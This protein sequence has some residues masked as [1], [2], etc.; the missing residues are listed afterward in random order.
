MKREKMYRLG[1]FLG[2]C[3]AEAFVT[4]GDDDVAEKWTDVVA[5]TF[6]VAGHLFDGKI[7][8]GIVVE[9]GKE[10]VNA[11]NFFS[12]TNLQLLFLDKFDHIFFQ[13]FIRRGR[14][15]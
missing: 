4:V 6:Q 5:E 14:C 8:T 10:V 7:L 9:R 11:E 2:D 13:I 12:I 1:S 3:K 15:G